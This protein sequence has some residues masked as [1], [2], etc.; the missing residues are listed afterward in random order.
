MGFAH[1]RPSVFLRVRYSASTWGSI[2]LCLS[3]G[4]LMT[5]WKPSPRQAPMARPVKCASALISASSRK[6]GA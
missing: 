5:S 4:A 1:D 2:A 6:T 3:L